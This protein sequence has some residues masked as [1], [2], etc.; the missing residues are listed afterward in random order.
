MGWRV[1]RRAAVDGCVRYRLRRWVGSWQP[2]MLSICIPSCDHWRDLLLPCLLSL[3]RTTHGAPIEVVIGDSGREGSTRSGCHEIGLQCVSIPQPFNF[4]RACNAM[5]AKVRG[6][7]LLFLNDDTKAVSQDWLDRLL[8]AHPAG[9]L[10]ALLV[11]PE[12][13]TLQ[14]AGVEVIRV[15]GDSDLPVGYREAARHGDVP[16]MVRHLGV[17]VPL[18][19]AARLDYS[20]S[21]AVTGAFLCTP[22]SCF[23]ALG[24]FDER[25]E[26]DLQDVDYCLRVRAAG[27]PVSCETDIVFTHA[28]SATRGAYPFPRAD[29]D[30]FL[31][32]WRTELEAWA[33]GLPMEPR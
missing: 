16:V 29:W 33:D 20:R 25:Y 30:L 8:A 13:R 15:T 7:Y 21:M 5:A 4:A 17:G 31:S 1:A 24:G 3:A 14:H 27:L 11:F 19:G 23:E 32:R 26:T 10:G 2:P 9:V 28:Q 18:A 22:R 12:S 6:A